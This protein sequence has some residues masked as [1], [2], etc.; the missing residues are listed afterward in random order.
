MRDGSGLPTSGNGAGKAGSDGT[1]NGLES[2]EACAL[3]DGAI[4]ITA[5]AKRGNELGERA[6]AGPRRWPA[7]VQVVDGESVSMPKPV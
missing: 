3:A 7:S 2:E 4:S 1:L 6:S 5:Q